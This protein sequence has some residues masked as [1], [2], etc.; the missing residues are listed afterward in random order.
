MDGGGVKMMLDEDESDYQ[1]PSGK[2]D[3]CGIRPATQWFGDTSCATCDDPKCI[4]WMQLDYDNH[5]YDNE[6]I[7]WDE[8]PY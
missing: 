2:C 7:V 4:A 1:H 6:D 8:D 3:V 5:R